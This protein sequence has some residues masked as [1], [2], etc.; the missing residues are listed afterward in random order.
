[1]SLDAISRWTSVLAT[2]DLYLEKCSSVEIQ[3]DGGVTQAFADVAPSRSAQPV[4]TI[5]CHWAN[6]HRSHLMKYEAHRSPKWTTLTFTT[7]MRKLCNVSNRLTLSTTQHGAFKGTGLLWL[8]LWSLVTQQTHWPE[9]NI[10]QRS[11]VHHNFV[12]SPTAHFDPSSTT[13]IVALRWLTP[14]TQGELDFLALSSS[15][16]GWSMVYQWPD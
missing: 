3:G 12:G 14:Q 4:Y 1:M 5:R 6:A 15:Y 16:S 11:P 10:G 9:Q 13:L 8:T 7:S 2:R